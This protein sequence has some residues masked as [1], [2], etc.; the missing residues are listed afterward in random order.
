MKAH[1]ERKHSEQLKAIAADQQTEE[2]TPAP[3]ESRKRGGASYTMLYSLC[4][5]KRRKELFSFTIKDWVEANTTLHH[6]SPK[7][8]S[9]HKIIFEYMIMDNIPFYE[10]S[11]PGFLR[12]LGVAEPRYKVPS[13]FYFRSMLEPAYNGIRY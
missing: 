4:P 10:A 6:G 9:L 8:Q 11:K 13:E 1:L 5:Q 2:T 7:A 12:M 3:V